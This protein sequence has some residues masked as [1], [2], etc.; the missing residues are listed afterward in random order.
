MTRRKSSRVDGES[1]MTPLSK[2]DY[3]LSS[4]TEGWNRN[5]YF[6]LIIIVLPSLLAVTIPVFP[7][8]PPSADIAI[9]VTDTLIILVIS[10][11][12]KYLIEWPWNWLRQ[13]KD[14]KAKI[15]NFANSTFLIEKSPQALEQKLVLIKKLLN[16][17]K[18][19][20]GCCVLGIVAGAL[21]MMYTR[22][23][24]IV[25]SSRQAIVFTN[26]NII[27]FVLW[28]GF[29]LVSVILE[30]IRSFSLSGVDNSNE[31]NL[32]T[33]SNIDDF[34]QSKQAKS[35]FIAEMFNRIVRTTSTVDPELLARAVT[36]IKEELNLES[37]T[38]QLKNKINTSEFLL[39][40]SVNDLKTEV[41]TLR[42]QLIQLSNKNN[43]KEMPKE[44]FKEMKKENFKEMKK[45]NFKP[46]PLSLNADN[47][48]EFNGHSTLK[49]STIGT[50]LTTIFENV[51][52]GHNEQHNTSPLKR[53]HHSLQY[54]EGRPVDK[55]LDANPT[56]LKKQHSL[57]G[58]PFSSKIKPLITREHKPRE[59]KDYNLDRLR[60]E[61]SLDFSYEP[62]KPSIFQL[63]IEMVDIIQK[64]RMEYPTKKVFKHPLLFRSIVENEISPFLKRVDESTFK[65]LQRIEAFK[66]FL[67]KVTTKTMIHN[68]YMINSYLQMVYDR[69]LKSFKR[70]LDLLKY[71][72]LKTP[73]NIITVSLRII[74]FFPRVFVQT[75]IVYP[76][77]AL[78]SKGM[79]QTNDLIPASTPIS[80]KMTSSRPSTSSTNSSIS[81]SGMRK[82]HLPQKLFPKDYKTK[83]LI[84]GK[85][86]DRIDGSPDYKYKP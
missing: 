46:F 85:L 45:E 72:F 65:V 16:Y 7:S 76:I 78:T 74:L 61:V 64:I 10:W 86:A 15:L 40:L 42:S 25:E 83:K 70:G 13:I 82:L 58:L 52:E 77:L 51:E 48:P 59:I 54:Q 26:L 68:Y 29:K 81:F 9:L 55:P 36:T 20:L 2:V 3:E 23:H 14:S 17:E 30:S 80:V 21:L 34:L 4:S 32:I 33:E 49:S 62:K 50:T 31:Y 63:L 79:N 43:F 73:Y 39:K 27:L 5:H 69:Y 66:T 8:S 67:W 75:L 6:A 28:G 22:E 57:H 56:T 24:V 41:E 19:A 11:I 35:S 60:L 44:N 12:I 18:V 84:L 47:S 38:N 53:K 37:T 1:N 71:M